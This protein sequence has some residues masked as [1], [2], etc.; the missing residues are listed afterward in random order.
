MPH[1]LVWLV[2]VRN[3]GSNVSAFCGALARKRLADV[4]VRHRDAILFTPAQDLPNGLTN[5]VISIPR[6]WFREM[7]KDHRLP[8]VPMM[9]CYEGD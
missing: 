9:F 7:G 5:I 1:R 4:Q 6:M 2:S 8:D 3:R